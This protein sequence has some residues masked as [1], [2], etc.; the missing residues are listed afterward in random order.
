MVVTGR[1][2]PPAVVFFGNSH[3]VFSNRHFLSLVESACTVVG[4]VDAPAARR[5]STHPAG[6]GDP[7]PFTDVARSRA[8]RLSRPRDPNGSAFVDTMASLSPDLF[9]AVGYPCILKAPLLSV[10]RIVS[11]NFHA[12]L[13]PAYRG[14]HPVFWALRHGEPWAGLTVHVMD[15]KLDAGDILYQVKVRTRL[16]DSV[17]SLYGRI[18]DRSVTLVPQLVRD[19]GA[20][21]LCRRRQGRQGASYYSGTRDGD[22]RL[23]WRQPAETLRRW[24]A[25]TPGRCFLES[26]GQRVFVL[27]ADA[28]AGRVRAPAGTVVRIGRTTCTVATGR[29]L[30]RLRRATGRAGAA[31]AAARICAALGVQA[32]DRL[33]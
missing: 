24:I 20:G 10:P 27:D 31:H 7:A 8:V 22:F 28:Q 9:V 13:L 18:M 14:K 1:T 19:A 30:L 32:G 11:A 4:A 15:P 21:T 2:G 17:A 25:A 23:D 33:A 5:G 26:R 16:R 29:G 6:P 3:S 12:S